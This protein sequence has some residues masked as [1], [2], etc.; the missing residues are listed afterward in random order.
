MRMETVTNLPLIMLPGVSIKV[1]VSR[2]FL[3]DHKDINGKPSV[4]FDSVFHGTK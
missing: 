3:S 1:V 4:R 2:S